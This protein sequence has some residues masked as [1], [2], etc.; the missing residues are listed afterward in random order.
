MKRFVVL[1]SPIIH[2][3]ETETETSIQDEYDSQQAFPASVNVLIQR[4]QKGSLKV[5]LIAESGRWTVHG[6][7]HL[8]EST[9]KPI[10]LLRDSPE[11]L[12]TGP[13]FQQLDEEVQSLVESYLENRG[14]NTALALFIPD[15]IDVKEQKEY[16]GWLGRVKDFVE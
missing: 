12:Y 9:S 14:I 16:L 8:T 15:Y 4:P 3:R 10:E 6:I 7:T 11:V 13:P 1:L 5:N 2:R